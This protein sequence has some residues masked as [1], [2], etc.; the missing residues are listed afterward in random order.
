MQIK[1][2]EL[3]HKNDT[4]VDAYPQLE[5]MYLQFNEKKSHSHTQPFI[6]THSHANVKRNS[7]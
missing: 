1:K 7:N 2:I 5:S 6:L 3:N 4:T